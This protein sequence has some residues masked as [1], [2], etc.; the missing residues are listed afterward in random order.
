L[1]FQTFVIKKREQSLRMTDFG[2]DIAGREAQVLITELNRFGSAALVDQELLR[3]TPTYVCHHLYQMF[4]SRSHRRA[5]AA[6]CRPTWPM[7]RHRRMPAA[8]A[9]RFR[10]WVPAGSPSNAA[11]TSRRTARGWG[12]N[13]TSSRYIV[14]S[15]R[16]SGTGVLADVAKSPPA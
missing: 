10:S 1:Q 9:V 13:M 16:Y 2:E 14:L 3:V 7:C 12:V 5:L 6:P 15:D 4:R 11:R 8:G